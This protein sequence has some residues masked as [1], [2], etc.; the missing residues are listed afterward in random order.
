MNS[1]LPDKS[2][3][4]DIA[5]IGD[6]KK[7]M[8]ARNKVFRSHLE[9]RITRE[10]PCAV[11]ILIDQSGSMGRSYL[12]S[13]QEEKRISEEVADAINYFL[14]YLI[15]RSTNG[16]EIREYFKFLI[17]GYG[18]EEKENYASFV[19]EGNLKGK[20]WISVKELAENI[21]EQTTKT[22]TK[23]HHW[24]EQ[25]EEKTTKKI[26]VRAKANGRNTPMLSALKL[27][28]S[29]IEEFIETRSDNFPPIVFNLTDGLPTD[30]E[31]LS[32]LIEICSEIKNI[33]TSFGNTVLFN[34]LLSG[35]NENKTFLPRL[36]EIEKMEANKYHYSLFES[37]SILPDFIL[38]EAYKIFKDEKYNSKEPIKSLVLNIEPKRLIELLKI[39][40][41]TTK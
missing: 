27:C 2:K 18:N 36:S 14:E 41:R 23:I 15:F 35:Q 9:C 20:D 38:E 32:D 37:S 29:K 24:G 30:I 4:N 19:W 3:T 40:T 26:W 22:E 31:D 7:I 25:Y 34:C 39:G 10:N 21:L 8:A 6:A 33:D 13:K 28:K 16:N 11:I 5:S 1:N 17:I 12:N